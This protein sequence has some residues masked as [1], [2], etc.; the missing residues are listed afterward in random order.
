MPDLGS[1]SDTELRALIRALQA[2]ERRESY[3]R[4]ILHGKIGILRAEL[5][6]RADGEAAEPREP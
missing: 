6:H 3:E 5:V 1:L 2:E 4:K